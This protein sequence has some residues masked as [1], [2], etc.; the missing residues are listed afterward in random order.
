MSASF[1]SHS[2]L[3]CRSD[4]EGPPALEEIN[5]DE[6]PPALEEVPEGFEAMDDGVRG[7]SKSEKKVRKAIEKL[8][9]KK[10]QGITRVSIKKQKTVFVIKSP[11]VYKAGKQD[12]Y[13]IFGEANVED[14]AAT[15]LQ[16]AYAQGGLPGMDGMPPGLDDA[17][18]G[19]DDAGPPELVDVAGGDAPAD[20][21]AADDG[22]PVDESGVESKDIELVMAQ[23]NCTRAQAVKALKANDS[24]IVNA[25]MELSI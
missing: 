17:P 8:G 21:A 11:D 25:I 23:V 2:H 14:S 22:A 12:G 24:D 18:P 9:L 13:V 10:V 3:L 7:Q 6:A 16:N 15:A 19:L 5:E 4:D 20:A 1:D